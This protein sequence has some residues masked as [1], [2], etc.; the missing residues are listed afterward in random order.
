MTDITS[1]FSEDSRK[2]TEGDL[3]Y[4]DVYQM[5]SS[6]AKQGRDTA[7]LCMKTMLG[8]VCIRAGNNSRG[9]FIE[10]GCGLTDYGCRE[11]IRYRRVVIGVK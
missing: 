1:S 4:G 11:V 2:C 7:P 8:P 9:E 5:C 10:L 6:L 3:V